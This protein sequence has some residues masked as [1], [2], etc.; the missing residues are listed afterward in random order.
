MIDFNKIYLFCYK[1]HFREG[2]AVL[3]DI[4][5]VSKASNYSKSTI[6]KSVYQPTSNN[7]TKVI[8]LAFESELIQRRFKDNVNGE[9]ILQMIEKRNK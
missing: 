1:N 6:L 8:G 4:D 2:E 7:C 5:Y 3:G 9:D